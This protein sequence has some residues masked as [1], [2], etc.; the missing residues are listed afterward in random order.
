MKESS[1]VSDGQMPIFVFG[2]AIIENEEGDIL[3]QKAYV[4]KEIWKI[5]GGYLE[6]RESI[7]NAVI[8]GLNETT[9]LGIEVD[10]MIGV[11]SRLYKR[12]EDV[13]C[14]NVVVLF[15]CNILGE[16]CFLESGLH[17]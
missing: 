13:D 16:A 1:Y 15:K 8:R 2:A 9:G 17:S 4:D 3:L 11:Y 5:P 7:E 14:Q 6:P 10:Y 12:I